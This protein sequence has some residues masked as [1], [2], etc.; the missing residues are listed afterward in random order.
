M[1]AFAPF[2]S[3]MSERDLAGAYIDSLAFAREGGRKAGVLRVVALPRVRDALADDAG[4]LRFELRGER[5]RQGASFLMLTVDGAVS[6]Q[7]Q[8]CLGQ[9]EYPL[10]V[11]T[12]LRLVPPGKPWPEDDLEDDSADAVEA[13]QEMALLP[14]LEDE[15]LLA[16]P[17]APR[18]GQC[19]PPAPLK[20]EQ[21]PS[22][23]AVLAKLKQS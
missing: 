2:M 19:E 16:L 7:C 5:D 4:E 23:F 9:M 10:R 1:I 6:L 14:L 12:R 18:H 8:R 21:E 20:D 22:P 13:E 3:S 15:I 17:I 11:S